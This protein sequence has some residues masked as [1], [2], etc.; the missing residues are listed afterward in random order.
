MCS[1]KNKKPHHGASLEHG[2]AHS[3]DHR[4]WSRRDF[5]RNL[6]MAGAGSAM[7]GGMPLTAF[8]FSPL[9]MSLNNNSGRILVVIRL[10]GGNDGLNTFVPIYDYG[11]YSSLRP[12]LAIPQN[13]LLQLTPEFGMPS[14]MSDL[15]PLWQDGRMKVINSVGYEEQNLSHFRSMDIWESASDANVMDSSGWLGRLVEEQYPDLLITPPDHPPAIQIGAPDSKMFNSLD[16]VSLS[17]S[18]SRAE[19]L[20]AI[21]QT[22]ELFDAN[23]PADCYG[24]EQLNFL[25]AVTNNTYKYFEVIQQAY[26]S[27]ANGVDYQFSL[28]A[29]LALVARMI[30]GGLNTSLYMVSI[31]GFDT[32][33]G[34]ED[35]HPALLNELASQVKNFF[36]DLMP[37]GHDQRVLC[38]TTSE[39]GRRIEENASLGTD[40]GSAAPLML[41]GAGLNGNGFLG[42]NPDLQDVDNIGNLKYDVDFRRI[43]SSVLT[44]WLCLDSGLI[45]D[46]LGQDFQELDLGLECN[47][48]STSGP[49]AKPDLSSEVRYSPDGTVHFHYTLSQNGQV[50]VQLFDLSGRLVS[51]LRNEYQPS[52][53]YQ[54]SWYPSQSMAGGLY[55]LRL[56]QGAVAVSKRVR[57]MR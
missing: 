44:N 33:A 41:F 22:G 42:E 46:V 36:D 8:R 19:E 45:G 39:F 34:Q 3:R 13:E 53:E 32:H 2:E 30:K 28:G 15:L 16:L 49:T 55:V 21:A 20:E 10:T 4:F 17:F 40:H 7:L 12:N 51:T 27:S 54:L 25:R 38:M 57:V 18:V 6:G 47:V 26:E 23:G 1:P 29:Q 50:K 31:N 5:L 43:Y 9:G 56:Q 52:G 35:Y 14:Y 48:V 37:G 24:G 11:T